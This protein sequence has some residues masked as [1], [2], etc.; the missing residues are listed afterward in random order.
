MGCFIRTRLTGILPDNFLSG[1]WGWGYWSR[2][3]R[4]IKTD[5]Q[6]TGQLPQ[7]GSTRNILANDVRYTLVVWYSED[8]LELLQASI[9]A[10]LG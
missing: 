6:R 10:N 9:Q 7:L 5:H 2:T 3:R 4:L 8:L 1:S